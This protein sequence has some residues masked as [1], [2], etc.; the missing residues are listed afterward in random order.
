[1]HQRSFRRPGPMI[2][3]GP[4]R[5]MHS[6]WRKWL[7]LPRNLCCTP[8]LY[9]FLRRHSSWHAFRESMRHRQRVDVKRIGEYLHRILNKWQ[10]SD[11]SAAGGH[12]IRLDPA[13]DPRLPRDKFPNST[14]R[15]RA[16]IRCRIKRRV[17]TAPSQAN[18]SCPNSSCPKRHRCRPIISSSSSSINSTSSNTSNISSS[19]TSMRMHSMSI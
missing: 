6:L 17:P 7:P 2:P 9:R 13:I 11:K 12:M 8:L 16:P 15:S 4:H 10:Q 19:N 14:V 3:T 18:S 1:M 5:P